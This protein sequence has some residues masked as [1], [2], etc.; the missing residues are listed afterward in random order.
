MKMMGMDYGS[1]A[2]EKVT[3]LKLSKKGPIK[4]NIIVIEFSNYSF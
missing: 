4:L 2:S 1:E 3:R